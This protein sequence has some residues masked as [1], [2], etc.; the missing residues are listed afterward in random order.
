MDPVV[1]QQEHQLSQL[2]ASTISSFISGPFL[3]V[4]DTDPHSPYLNYEC[5]V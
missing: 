5:G 2:E 4:L 1:L 3:C